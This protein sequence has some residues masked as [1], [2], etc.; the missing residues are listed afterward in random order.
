VIGIR[1]ESP[2]D[3]DYIDE[4]L[5]TTFGQP[6]EA[7]VVRKLRETPDLILALIAESHGGVVG[8]IAF[9][10]LAAVTTGGVRQLACL[11][12]MAVRP[13][14]QRKGI[15][16]ALI[17]R[18]LEMLR[19]KRFPAVIVVGDPVYY[20]RFG[21]KVE[22]AALLECPYSGPYLQGLELKTGFFA[23]LGAA[24]LDFSPPLMP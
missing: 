14:R 17:R 18:G 15:G 12:P 1:P 7:Q 2:E 8:H 5:T 4:L 6:D 3:F 19:E 9:S 23:G 11:A 13:S 24:R 21:F 16:A 10:R 20:G 22:S